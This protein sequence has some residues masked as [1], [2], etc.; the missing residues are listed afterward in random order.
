MISVAFCI[1]QWE[2]MLYMLYDLSNCRK[3]N[4]ILY[5]QE[6]SSQ[7]IKEAIFGQKNKSFL[8]KEKLYK[9]ACPFHFMMVKCKR[10]NKLVRDNL[11]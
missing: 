10:K 1:R 8:L 3:R 9:V 2:N 4:N 11:L 6:N 7:G 5:L